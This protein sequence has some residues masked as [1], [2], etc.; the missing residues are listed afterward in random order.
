MFEL[1][2]KY[3]QLCMLNLSRNTGKFEIEKYYWMDLNYVGYNVLN[4]FTV[5]AP[6][7]SSYVLP[8]PCLW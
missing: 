1:K 2:E 8:F 3:N 5:D 7:N 6:Y 4:S